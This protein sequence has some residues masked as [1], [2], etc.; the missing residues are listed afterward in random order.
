VECSE[1]EAIYDQGCEVVVEVLL[2]MDRRV[3]QLGARVARQD[4]WFAKFE[5]R[6][7]RSSEN[8]S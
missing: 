2:A 7:K 6:L 3:G 4:E 5:R 1:A 8:S